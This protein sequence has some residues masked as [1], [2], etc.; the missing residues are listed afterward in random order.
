LATSKPIVSAPPQNANAG[1]HIAAIVLF[2]I[3]GFVALVR[4]RLLDVPLERDEGEYAYAGQLILQGIPPYLLAYNMKFPGTYAAYALIM[5]I[6]GETTSA[7]R[8][9]LLL[10]NAATM[11]LLY[12]LTRRLFD[13]ATGLIAAASFALMSL[14][15][16]IRGTWAHAT[17]FVI[18]PVV[19][20]MLLLIRGGTWRT[21]FAGALLML[22]I[23]MKQPAAAFAIFAGIWLLIE[24]R[25]RDASRLAGGGAVIAAIT[26]VILMVSGVFGRFW[27]WTIQYAREYVT[28]AAAE[29]AANLFRTST[30]AIFGSEPLLW[31]LAAAGLVM[32][33]VESKH[34]KFILGFTLAG[35][36]AVLPG[37]YFRPHYFIVLLPA[38]AMLIGIAVTGAQRLIASRTQSGALRVIPAAIF[39]IAILVTIGQQS[40]RWFSLSGNAMSRMVYDLNPFPEAPE[41]AKYLA[42]HTAPDDRIAI[43]GSEPE[44]YFYAN[45]KS[46]TGYIYTY[47]LMEHQK[48]AR[49]M[50]EEMIRE[51]TASKPK[52]LVM[53]S[54][55]AS[56]LRKKDSDPLI[57]DWIVDQAKS[58]KWVVDGIADVAMSDTK[59]VWGPDAAAYR[60]R[61][62]NVVTLYRVV[63]GGV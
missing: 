33:F 9:G 53:V 51:I 28:S 50:Q 41:I 5:A 60:P 37:L 61:S 56:W 21:L 14:E 20:A 63:G 19:A 32:L 57:F 24:K 22:A 1:G 6:F 54:M 25:W 34:R 10:V 52:Y 47:P 13:R 45:R 36:V 16:A 2:V 23:L 48:F 17:H 27:F 11:L 38:A 40:D 7:I 8:L 30:A 12:F 42:E 46:A 35:I 31:I 44:I 58:G 3:L 29:D 15:I 59:F 55:S 26:G 49:T 43:L 18:L 62:G 39:A 4:L